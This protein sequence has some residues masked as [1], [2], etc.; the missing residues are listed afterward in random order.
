MRPRVE[1]MN[2]VDDAILEFYEEQESSLVLPPKIVWYNLHSV[3]SV[4]DKSAETVRRRMK[5]L[6]KRG[7]LERV[8][9]D[10]AYYRLTQKGRNYLVGE[11]EPDDLRLQDEH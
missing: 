1:G 2:A 3:R 4:I 6:D 11:V 9:D 10:R 7:L 8:E 5:K